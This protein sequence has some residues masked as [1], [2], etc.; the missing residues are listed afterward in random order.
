MFKIASCPWHSV[1]HMPMFVLHISHVKYVCKCACVCHNNIITWPIWGWS[2]TKS[3]MQSISLTRPNQS[4]R[5]ETET[6]FTR[7]LRC[8]NLYK[9]DQSITQFK[10]RMN[11]TL[12][13]LNKDN[14]RIIHHAKFKII[15]IN[16][17][18]KLKGFHLIHFL[19]SHH[20]SFIIHYKI[21]HLNKALMP[22]H[23][24]QLNTYFFLD[25]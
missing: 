19:C 4:R 22:S 24:V 12:H 5:S 9:T 23:W 14:P 15:I 2:K 11:P 10:Y 17:T 8:A 20:K 6:L 25:Q 1:S 13:Q 16:Q 21:T 3:Q 7:S 18:G